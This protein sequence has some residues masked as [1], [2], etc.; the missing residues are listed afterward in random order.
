[1][2]PDSAPTT[3]SDATVVGAEVLGPR[4]APVVHWREGRSPLTL[5]QVHR[6]DRTGETAADPG[7]PA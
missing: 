1:M 6:F 4:A 7:P 3:P 2:D 5:G